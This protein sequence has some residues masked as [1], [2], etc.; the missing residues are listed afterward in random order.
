MLAPQLG[1]ADL[2][3]AAGNREG[4]DVG[5]W[6]WEELDDGVVLEGIVDRVASEIASDGDWNILVRPAPAT[7][8]SS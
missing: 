4:T 2:G 7:A 8:T 3:F 1:P 6:G 5:I